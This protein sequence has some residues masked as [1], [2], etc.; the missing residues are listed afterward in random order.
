MCVCVCVLHS[1]RVLQAFLYKW[2]NSSM[3]GQRYVN[4][5]TTVHKQTSLSIIY[6]LAPQLFYVTD[7]HRLLP[8]LM[9]VELTSVNVTAFG[10][11]CNLSS[12]RC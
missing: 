6:Y 10:S 4:G 3:F 1:N 11:K 12:S 7:V 8:L 2:I 5:W 9:C